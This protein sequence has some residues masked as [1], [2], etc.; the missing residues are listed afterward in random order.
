MANPPDTVVNEALD[1]Q[2]TRLRTRL[3]KTPLPGF[4][5]WWGSQLLACLPEHWRTRMV[6]NAEFLLL[7]VR[8]RELVVWRERAG[9]VEEFGRIDLDQPAEAQAEDFRRLR[10]RVENP[11]VRTVFCI[12]GTR[13]LTRTLSLPTAAEDNLR[14]VLAFEMDRQTPFKADQVYFDSRVVAR[15]AAARNMRVELV[16]LPRTALDPEM[17]AFAEGSVALDGVDIWKDAAGSRRHHINLLPVERRA[18]RRN[19]RLPLN[20]GL[21]AIA[22]VLLVFNMSESLSNRAAAV[23]AMSA[24]VDQARAAATEVAELRKTLQDSIGGANFLSDKKRRGPVVVGL[25]DDLARRLNDD[26]YLERLHIENNQIQLHGQSKEAANLIAVLGESPY[27]SSPRF[28]GQIQP[29]PRTGKDR[30]TISADPREVDIEREFG[31]RGD[32]PPPASDSPQG[33][34]E[35]APETPAAEAKPEPAEAADAND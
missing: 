35:P 10:L 6:G 22:I 23:Q 12:P 30:F 15:D 33:T 21:A 31:A 3:A 24:A 18:R 28:D 2:L 13:A 5:A 17:S 1:R 7:E 20:L 8:E 32:T 34:Q 25:L 11:N 14:Q 4:F 19:V 29:D 16:V 26:T 27:L 9:R